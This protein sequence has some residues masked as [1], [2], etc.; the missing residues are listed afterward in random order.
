MGRIK[1]I[2]DA[3]GILIL[4]VVYGHL[5][6]IAETQAG[7]T[8]FGFKAMTNFLFLP[9]YMPAFF[10]ITG[11]CSNFD[12][13][14]FDF[15][16]KNFLS[17]IVPNLLIGVFLS[18]W[19]GLFLS[20]GI[21][22]NN[23]ADIDY[24]KILLT[25]GGWFLPA[26]FVSK[27]MLRFL[28]IITKSKIAIFVVSLVLMICGISL[29]N[30]GFLNIWYYQHALISLPFLAVG[31]CL[32]GREKIIESNIVPVLGLCAVVFC[33]FNKYP[34]LNAQP[35][36]YWGNS[37]LFVILSIFGSFSIL[38]ICRK[39]LPGG[40]MV[41][42]HLGR[43]LLTIYLLHGIFLAF[44]IRLSVRFGIDDVHFYLK[45]IVGL[46][47]VLLSAA[48]CYFIDLLI[49]KKAKILKGKIS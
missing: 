5:D 34:F 23:F 41:M 25:T 4:L 9:Y 2:D 26:L 44:L 33:Y 49:D 16:K 36:F 13:P 39:L 17:L 7:T 18:K 42:S 10:I 30:Q 28:M 19:I 40:V 1:W 47:I 35:H 6:Y 32:K 11:F 29:F 45:V 31:Y 14:H 20:D 12:K 21:S 46:I 27:V 43:H 24:V 37:W 15:I 22:I 3:K 48:I 8:A 38:W